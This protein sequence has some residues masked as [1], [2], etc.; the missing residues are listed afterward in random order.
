MTRRLGT[1]ALVEAITIMHVYLILSLVS[2]TITIVTAIIRFI[3]VPRAFGDLTT[4][5]SFDDD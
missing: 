1:S 3:E 4:Y 5:L 2:F